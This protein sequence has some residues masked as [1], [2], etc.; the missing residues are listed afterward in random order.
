[1]G[2]ALPHCVT[3]AL[4]RSVLV[5]VPVTL[6]DL[7]MEGDGDRVGVTLTLPLTVTQ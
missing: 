1:M 2:V 3:V 4:P 5:Y 6:P 7:L